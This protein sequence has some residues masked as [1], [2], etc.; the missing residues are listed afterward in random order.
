MK[1]TN[2]LNEVFNK[3]KYIYCDMDGVLV[4]F[5]KGF[6]QQFGML[7]NEFETKYGSK[8]FWNRVNGGGSKF[9]RDLPPMPDMDRLWNFISP[10]IKSLLTSPSKDQSSLIGK[11]GWV[12][13]HLSPKPKVLFRY[14]KNKQE[15]LNNI[16][17]DERSNYIMIDDRMEVV[18]N[19]IQA[20]GEAILHR[21][22]DQTIK[23]LQRLG[24]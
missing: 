14:T 20:G 4:D 13:D 1:L 6:K 18:Q 23:E 22:A 5:D 10:Y 12:K 16:P 9:W 24:L 3:E 15:V 7:P 8:E 19:W 21:S 17:E 11:Y 2:I